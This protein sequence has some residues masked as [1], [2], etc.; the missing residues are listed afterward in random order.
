MRRF[1]KKLLQ[2]LTLY[3]TFDGQ[4]R[5]KER[6][7][8]GEYVE[9]HHITCRMFCE[10][11]LFFFFFYIFL[12]ALVYVSLLSSPFLYV[13][14]YSLLCTSPDQ[15][16]F[17]QLL[18]HSFQHF[19]TFISSID[20]FFV[21]LAHT[22]VSF[23]SVQFRFRFHYVPAK[24]DACDSYFPNIFFSLRTFIHSTVII[25]FNQFTIKDFNFPS[26]LRRCICSLCNAQTLAHS[27]TDYILVI[28]VIVFTLSEHCRLVLMFRHHTE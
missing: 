10:R 12:A 6:E 19:S 8:A 9:R 14:Y 7:R 15:S 1:V 4:G 22:F 5:E 3:I 27:R 13:I 23:D 28:I 25:S 11:K 18:M 21:W 26:I 20:F 17:T 16:F 2:A 24:S